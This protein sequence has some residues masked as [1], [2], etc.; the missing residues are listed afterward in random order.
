MSR[1]MTPKNFTF[2]PVPEDLALRQFREAMADSGVFPLAGL[3]SLNIVRDGKIHKF[4][5]EG[6]RRGNQAG[7]YL[8]YNDN[9]PIAGWFQDWRQMAEPVPWCFDYR[10]L[11]DDP[12]YRTAFE[13]SHTPE[14]KAAL[15]QK[16]KERKKV[17]AEERARASDMARA[18][19]DTCKSAPEDHSYLVKKQVAKYGD[20]RLAEDD[21]LIPLKDERGR[22][23]SYQRIAPDG[24][25]KFCEGCPVRGARFTIAEDIAEGP[26]LVAEGYATAAT[27]YEGTNMMTVCAI[28]CHNLL[29]VCQSLRKAYPGRRI[30]LMADDDAGTKEKTG[31]NPG[32]AAAAECVK[33]R[34]ADGIC[35]PLFDRSKDGLGPSDWNDYAS[36]YGLDATEKTLNDSI[37]QTCISKEEKAQQRI[38]PLMRDL[39]STIK[40]P[41]VEFI[42]GMFPKGKISAVVS[43]PGMGKTWFV[44]R[45]VTDLSN[46]GAI[47]GGFAYERAPIRCLV[48]AGE[49]GYEMMIQRA[50]AT[51][52]KANKDAVKIVSV[53][54]GA[55]K[56]VDF[57]LDTDTGRMNIEATIDLF[58]PEIVFFDTLISFHDKD[59]NKSVEMKPIFNYLLKLAAA[60][61][62]AIV[63]MHHTRKPTRRERGQPIT[64]ADAIGTS[65]FNRL[66]ALM[67][68]MEI[69]ESPDIDLTRRVV[70]VRTLKS[71]YAT[72]DPFTFEII[73][74]DT[75]S[76]IPVRM[77]IDLD[78]NLEIVGGLK[79]KIWD[80]IERTYKPGEWFKVSDV[81]GGTKCSASHARRYL[82]RWVQDEKLQRRGER[83]S[84]GYALPTF[85]KHTIEATDDE[86][87]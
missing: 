48:L 54:E 46:G 51:G 23:M 71:W 78:P 16:Q 10:V 70:L 11:R 57:V 73:A 35:S 30:I 1:Q 5:V 67:V 25:K 17:E 65:A 22:F 21:L 24:S 50:K 2:E 45:F 76:G 6:G 81:T 40:V 55:E 31:K 42:G 60:K 43:E 9:G 64:Q 75:E 58:K 3:D 85:Y 14:F 59:E 8:L 77:E 62:I 86:G 47:F 84:T 74:G 49:A 36:I 79:K 53:T 61:N 87:E 7:R 44:L 34:V 26:I 83:K 12:N 80:F 4:D 32:M 37:A 13:Q 68:G 82:T 52:W 56:G 38:A 39:D 20:L 69:G 15:N 33:A 18:Y 28:N 29:P 66:T 63:L 41:P 19:F 72:F 27:V